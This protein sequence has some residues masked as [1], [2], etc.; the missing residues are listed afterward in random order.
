MMPDG[1]EPCAAFQLRE[2]IA[3]DALDAV[4]AIYGDE[5]LRKVVAHMKR[6]EDSRETNV[7]IDE[8]ERLFGPLG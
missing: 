7:E 6:I 3:K 5:G 4:I 1:A 8:L 2:R